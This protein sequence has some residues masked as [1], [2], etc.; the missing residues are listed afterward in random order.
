M[1]ELRFMDFRFIYPCLTNSRDRKITDAD[2]H[3][4]QSETK[5]EPN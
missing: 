3:I 1:Y 5:P 4:Y 2:Y